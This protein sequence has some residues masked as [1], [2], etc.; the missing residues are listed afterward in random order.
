MNSKAFIIGIHPLATLL[1]CLLVLGAGL[2]GCDSAGDDALDALGLELRGRLQISEQPEGINSI[3]ATYE[4]F[5]AGQTVSIAGRIYAESLSPFDATEATFTVIE[6]PKP[7]HNHEDPGDCPFCKRELRNAKFAVVKIMNTDGQVVPYS[8]D[9][10]LGLQKN[11]DIAV[12]GSAEL[13]GDTMIVSMDSYH[14]LS[15]EAAD[16]LSIAFREAS[17]PASATSPDP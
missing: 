10:L 13:V 6:L 5:Q 14:L 12:S 4:S 17:P 2:A 8:A 16:S 11:Q 7:G 1:G 3:R 15:R 9:R